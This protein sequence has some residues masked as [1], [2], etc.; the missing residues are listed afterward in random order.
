M[1]Q[2][3]ELEKSTE[4]TRE[5]LAAEIKDLRANQPGGKTKLYLRCKTDCIVTMRV[6]ESERI[7]KIK[8]KIIENNE[9][10][11]MRERKLIDPQGSIRELSDYRGPWVAWSI[12]HPT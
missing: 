3:P 2:I 9:A 10:E 5:I 7:G 1:I 12:K 4:D 8:D 11:K 6:E